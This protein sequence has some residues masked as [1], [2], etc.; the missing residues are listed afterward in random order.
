MNN[1]LLTSDNPLRV[2]V[3]KVDREIASLLL[4]DQQT[5][6]INL[7]YLPVGAK[8]GDILYLDLIDKNKLNQSKKEIA[9]AVLEEILG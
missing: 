4:P 9:K 3:F 8:E 5:F 6:Q 2:K 7:K 1:A